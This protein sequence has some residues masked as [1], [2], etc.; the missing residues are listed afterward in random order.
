VVLCAGHAA[1]PHPSGDLLR[2]ERDATKLDPQADGELVTTPY[3]AHG[4]GVNRSSGC[5]WS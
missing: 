3:E 2:V 4:S 1:L 5:S